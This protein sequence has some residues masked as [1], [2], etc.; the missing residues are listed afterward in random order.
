MDIKFDSLNSLASNAFAKASPADYADGRYSGTILRVDAVTTDSAGNFCF[1][2][3]INTQID[4]H[5][6]KPNLFVSDQV[7]FTVRTE[8]DGA[9]A[10]SISWAAVNSFCDLAAIC[11]ADRPA[12]YALFKSFARSCE[13]GDKVAMRDSMLAI[14]EIAKILPGNRVAPNIVWSE[15]GRYA[16]VRGSRTMPS[17]LSA[18]TEL[19]PGAQFNGD[20]TD[21]NPPA[22]TRRRN[23]TAKRK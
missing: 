14:G 22:P 23:L 3:K 18:A 1:R 11:G 16:N 12:V 19:D 9:V 20:D 7:T 10:Y 6:G 5:P 8:S 13:S 15:D 21:D 4:K 17:Y 2:F